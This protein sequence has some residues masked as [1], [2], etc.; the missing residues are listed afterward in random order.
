MVTFC[1]KQ[2]TKIEQLYQRAF[3]GYHVKQPKKSVLR[4]TDVSRVHNFMYLPQTGLENQNS[5]LSLHIS[6]F[7]CHLCL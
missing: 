2:S 5:K 3:C 1:L 6:F 7:F 4:K